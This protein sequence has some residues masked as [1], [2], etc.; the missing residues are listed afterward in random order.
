MDLEW[1]KDVEF[2]TRASCY[3]RNE[4]RVTL[5]SK[6]AREAEDIDLINLCDGGP[7]CHFGGRVERWGIHAKVSVYID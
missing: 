6:R 2:H 4:Y 3:G 7:G 5:I 1:G